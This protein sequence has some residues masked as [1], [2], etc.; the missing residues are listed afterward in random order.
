MSANWDPSP[1]ALFHLQTRRCQFAPPAHVALHVP[2]AF[3]IEDIVGMVRR[4][5]YG[6]SGFHDGDEEYPPGTRCT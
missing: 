4:G 6:K 3:E 5:F 2:S 1:R